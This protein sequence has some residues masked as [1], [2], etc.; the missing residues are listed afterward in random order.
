LTPEPA[1]S[2]PMDE[3]ALNSEP[4]IARNYAPL[5]V[6]AIL[7]QGCALTASTRVPQSPV[8]SN[9]VSTPTII[10]VAP[11]VR[12]VRS[13]IG[14]ASWYGPGFR[15]KKTAS[16]TIFDDA[17]FTAAH[18]TL[19]LGTRVRVTNLV[20]GKSVEVD[21]NDRGPFVEDRVIDL[22][23]AAAHALGMRDRGVAPVRLD[24]VDRPIE[25]M[26]N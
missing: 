23:Q 2:R 8:L 19:P 20:N 13:V 15:G 18:K 1:T 9:D 7:L 4:G 5:V 14:T 6:G 24:L 3:A 16:G 10:E 26:R 25:Q 11:A 22:S 12:P 21:I 17:K